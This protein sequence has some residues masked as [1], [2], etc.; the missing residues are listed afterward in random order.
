MC[1]F[2]VEIEHLT[3]GCFL[4]AEVLEA[5]EELT[6]PIREAEALK[7][8]GGGGDGTGAKAQTD[9]LHRQK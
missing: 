3:Q 6:Y 1:R 4:L 7:I 8:L 2:Q 5:T 9:P